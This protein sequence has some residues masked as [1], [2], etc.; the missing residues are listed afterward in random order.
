LIVCGLVNASLVRF[1]GKARFDK[2]VI[3]AQYRSRVID[4][5]FFQDEHRTGARVF[6]GSRTIGNNRLIARQ[7]FGA[8]FDVG[9]RYRQRPFD[10]AGVVYIFASNINYDGLIRLQ[11]SA[12]FVRGN[13]ARIVTTLGQ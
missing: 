13:A 12:N 3:T 10:M 4:S 7:L 11:Q 9:K 8:R 2:S 5:L 1:R 6:G